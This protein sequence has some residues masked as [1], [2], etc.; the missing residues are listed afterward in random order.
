[1]PP[2]AS[3]YIASTLNV[4][5]WCIRSAHFSQLKSRLSVKSYW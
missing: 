3:L 5:R 2:P 1:L 4:C